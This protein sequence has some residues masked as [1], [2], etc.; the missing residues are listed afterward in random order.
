MRPCRLSMPS[1]AS[2]GWRGGAARGGAAPPR[3]N[4]IFVPGFRNCC[5]RPTEAWTLSSAQPLAHTAKRRGKA[6]QGLGGAWRGPAPS[7][8]LEATEGSV[9]PSRTPLPTTGAPT[10][11][12]CVPGAATPALSPETRPVMTDGMDSRG[13][14]A[15]FAT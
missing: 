10:A 12:G 5:R 8:I 13:A 14:V 3:G 7:G 6:G 15:K 9:L 2:K 4:N 11:Y 1:V